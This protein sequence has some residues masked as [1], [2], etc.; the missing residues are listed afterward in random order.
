MLPP[1]AIGIAVDEASSQFPE[2][3][4]WERLLEPREIDLEELCAPPSSSQVNA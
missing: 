2:I 4:G 3:V 1:T